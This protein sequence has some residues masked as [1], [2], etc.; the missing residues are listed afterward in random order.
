MRRSFAILLMSLPLL[1]GTTIYRWTDAD[2]KVHF[3]DDPPSGAEEIQVGEPTVVSPPPASASPT[4]SSRRTVPDTSQPAY[5]TF[6]IVRPA[7]DAV[8]RDNLGRVP[9]QIDI[10]PPLRSGHR[11]EVRLDGE[12]HPDHTEPRSTAF[13]LHDVYRGTHTLE[14][15]LLDSAGNVVARSANQFHMHRATVN[16]P[17]RQNN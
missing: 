14:I 6:E 8:V 15:R 2:G 17:T 9:V 3:G 13:T 12:R 11:I 7:D 1:C 10:D 4:P 5:R 16:S